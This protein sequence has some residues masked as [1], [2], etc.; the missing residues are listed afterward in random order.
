MKTKATG[1]DGRLVEPPYKFA[2]PL[3]VH[4]EDGSVRSLLSHQQQPVS[5]GDVAF[6][7]HSFD[8]HTHLS[9]SSQTWKPLSIRVFSECFLL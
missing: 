9:C 4:K 1:R 3:G 6:T 5:H 8:L 7:Q 2:L